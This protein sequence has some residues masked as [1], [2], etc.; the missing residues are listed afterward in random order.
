MPPPEPRSKTVSPGLSCTRAVGFP[1]PS[2]ASKASLGICCDCKAS[3][4]LEV[5][6]S[7]Q[8]LLVVAPQHE[9]PPLFTRSAACPYF[10]LTT[11]FISVALMIPPYLHSRMIW[12]GLTTLLRV[13]HSAYRNC[14]TS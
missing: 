13:Q 2:E 9:L 14:S 12:S 3:Y 10:S 6:G 5:M 4:R 7:P 8:P 1:Q 11:S